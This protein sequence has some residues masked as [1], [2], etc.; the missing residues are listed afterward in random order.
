MNKINRTEVIV[1]NSKGIEITQKMLEEANFVK[2][3][4][5]QYHIIKDDVGYNVEIISY[6]EQTKKV[7]LKIEG[8]K[9]SCQVFD[10]LDL[11]IKKMGLG[12]DKARKI[13]S[14]NAPMPGK[15]LEILVKDGQTI[16]EGDSLLILEAMKMEN[17]IKSPGIGK[18]SK[19]NIKKGEAVEKGQVLISI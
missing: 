2:V 17:V 4:D 6:E 18:I 16:K 12:T 1:N 14:V 10:E 11:L 15:V 9:F 5:S 19:V 13:K 8:E 3:G 7:E